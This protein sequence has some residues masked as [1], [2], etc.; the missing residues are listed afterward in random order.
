MK[1]FIL[2]LIQVGLFVFSSQLWAQTSQVVDIPT[3]PGVTQR[4]VV[5]GS[6]KPK[7]A[8]AL[9]AGGHGCGDRDVGSNAT[10]PTQGQGE[11][12]PDN[13]RGVTA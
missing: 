12:V 4:M 6:E 3:R 10:F 9:F 5:L 1:R 8:V 13:F 11:K 7:A 2:V